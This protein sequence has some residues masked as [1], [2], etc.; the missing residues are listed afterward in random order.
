MTIIFMTELK[1]V[2]DNA[3]CTTYYN[4]WYM[5]GITLNKHLNLPVCDE[6]IHTSVSGIH[7]I[8]CDLISQLQLF[9]FRLRA[10]FHFAPV[11]DCAK[12]GENGIIVRLSGNTT[13]TSN[14]A[15]RKY[16]GLEGHEHQTR[17]LE[18]G[19]YLGCGKHID[20]GLALTIL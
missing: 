18:S 11:L 7:K 15:I 6:N 17:K 1:V 19:D 20:P 13:W 3:N 5:I 16:G 14:A 10:L 9:L 12:I 8:S 2:S 4:A